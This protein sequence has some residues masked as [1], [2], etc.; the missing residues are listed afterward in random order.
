MLIDG[1]DLKTIAALDRRGPSRSA[2]AVSQVIKGAPGAWRR[3]RLGRDAP[4]PLRIAITGGVWGTTL[5]QLQSRLDEF[6]HRLRPDAELVVTFSDISSRQWLGYRERLDVQDIPPD[7]MSEAVK[8]SL[9]ILCPMPFAEDDSLQN[10]ESN[11][12]PPRVI[13]PTVGSAP[14]PVV[15]KLT[16]NATA[17]TNPVLHYRDG[18]DTDI[19]TLSY[20]GSLNASQQLVIDTEAMTAEVNSV[21]AAGDMSGV[22]F[23][24]NPGDADPYG[25]FGSPTYPDVQLTADSGIAN[26]FR[27]EWRRRYW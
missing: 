10:Q 9:S 21:N 12:T 26:Q 23:D 18:S 8:F 15:I 2:A 22:Y 5:S 14:M 27:L 3:Q 6:K 24:V 1:F 20:S 7:W 25:H 17:L 11:G 13:T 19:W 16:G 4:A